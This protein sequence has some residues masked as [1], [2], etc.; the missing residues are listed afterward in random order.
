[1][2]ENKKIQ[3]IEDDHVIL[4]GLKAMLTEKGYFVNDHNG[5]DEIQNII[6]SVKMFN[7]HYLILDL[8]LPRADGYEILSK[9]KSDEHTNNIPV[10]IFSNFSE[11]DVKERCDRLGADYY[12]IKNNFSIEEFVVKVDKVIKNREISIK[13]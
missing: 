4:T 7:P 8:V 10:I 5:D 3:I 1:M 6:N 13:N 2:D 12:F 11:E 9:M